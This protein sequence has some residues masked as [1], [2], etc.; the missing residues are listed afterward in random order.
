M[1]GETLNPFILQ[2]VSAF[3][4]SF[5]AGDVVDGYDCKEFYELSEGWI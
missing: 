3:M 5:W 2:I 1:K 4:L